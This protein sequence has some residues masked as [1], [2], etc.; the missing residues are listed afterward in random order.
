MAFFDCSLYLQLK[1]ISRISS[2]VWHVSICVDSLPELFLNQNINIR[3]RAKYA[4]LTAHNSRR[5]LNIDCPITHRKPAAH[6]R[7]V[8]AV[9]ALQTGVGGAAH[10]QP[11]QGAVQQRPPALAARGRRRHLG[12]AGAL[13]DELDA[14]LLVDVG[15]QVLEHLDAWDEQ[16]PAVQHLRVGA[17]EVVVQQSLRVAQNGAAGLR[18]GGANVTDMPQ[19]DPV[20]CSPIEIEAGHTALVQRVG[21]RVAAKLLQLAGQRHRRPLLALRVHRQNGVVRRSAGL[22]DGTRGTRGTR[23]TQ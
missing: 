21:P 17:L 16:P 6:V 2:R 3:L 9:A 12:A 14:A 19:T 13:G 4:S 8:A 22:L 5:I 18:G 1:N 15:R 20:S 11:A 23:E 10:R 7:R